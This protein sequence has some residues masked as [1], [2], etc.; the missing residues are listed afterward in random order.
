MVL[1]SLGLCA[2]RGQA[3][4][5]GEGRPGAVTATTDSVPASPGAAIPSETPPLPVAVTSSTTAPLP[6]Q[7]AVGAVDASL[8]T[9]KAMVTAMPQVQVSS[10]RGA[11]ALAAEVSCDPVVP[12]DALA[13]LSW[14]PVEGALEQ[15][16]EVTIYGF[17]GLLDRSEPLQPNLGAITWRLTG[18]SVRTWR[19]LTQSAGGW[20]ASEPETFDMPECVGADS[21]P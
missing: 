4:P 15:R 6:P 16:V 20:M 13:R 21:I 10:L 3:Q 8:V 12:G 9:V 18:S 14:S 19:V 11:T 1:A 2:C 17:D 7:S 5:V